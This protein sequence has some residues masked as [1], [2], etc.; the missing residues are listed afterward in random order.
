LCKDM[1]PC[2]ERYE[3]RNRKKAKVFQLRIIN[4]FT[5]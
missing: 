3:Y 4:L 1:P 5:R 2:A